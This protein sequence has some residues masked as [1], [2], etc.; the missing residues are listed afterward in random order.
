MVLLRGLSRVEHAASL[1]VLALTGLL[2]LPAYAF[3]N[4][5]PFRMRYM[6]APCVGS[7]VFA[8]IALGM[9]QGWWRTAALLP[10]HS[11]WP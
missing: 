10:S 5:H 4:G 11:G 7:A 3:F 8:G 1:V 6:V 9:L 2:A